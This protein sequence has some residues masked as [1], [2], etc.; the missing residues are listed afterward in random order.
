MISFIVHKITTI[1]LLCWC[2]KC[3]CVLLILC[4]YLW[5]LGNE[6]A[7]MTMVKAL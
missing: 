6:S 4:S 3:L 7:V 2:F 1:E 5:N